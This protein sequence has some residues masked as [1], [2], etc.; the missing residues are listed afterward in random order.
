MNMKSGTEPVLLK[1]HKLLGAVVDSQWATRL[2]TKIAWH[3]IEN[4]YAKFGNARASLRYLEKATGSQRNKIINSLRR[5]TDNGA[6]SV[7]RQGAG[8]KSRFRLS[9]Q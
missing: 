5:L 8:T 3:V 6:I 2:D 7:I 9:E 1:Q 4:Y